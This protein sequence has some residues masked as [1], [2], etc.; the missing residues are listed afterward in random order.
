MT[1]IDT[2]RV[3][4][5]P[6]TSATEGRIT[7][8]APRSIWIFAHMAGGIAALVWYPGWDG[9]MVFLTLAAPMTCVIGTSGRPSARPTPRTGR[10]GC[11]MHGGSFIASFA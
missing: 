7:W 3:L 5:D 6:D 2:D 4:A 1:L 11:A 8:D 9:L 10:A